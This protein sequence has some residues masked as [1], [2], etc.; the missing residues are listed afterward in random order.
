MEQS[1]PGLAIDTSNRI[2][3][4]TINRPEALNAINAEVMLSLGEI[5][6]EIEDNDRIAGI[7]ITG[8][9]EKAFVAGADI[10]AF[11]FDDESRKIGELGHRVFN[12][13]ESCSKPVV[14][15]VNGFALGG[16]CELAMSCHLRLAGRHA[17]FGQPEINLGIIPGYGG[18]QRLPQLVGKGRAL[19]MLLTGEMIDAAEAYRI[20]LVN[21]VVDSGK[22]LEA[23]ELVLKKI[24]GKAPMAAAKIIELVN[25][26]F[27]DPEVGM[28]QEIE[29]FGACFKTEDAV[30]GV[31]AFIE[32]RRPNFVGK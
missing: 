3:T 28:L 10:K 14:A 20:G 9:G 19:E 31:K 5:F 16:G 1:Y 7:I 30:E 25:L 24:I 32:K 6:S 4:I 18:T 13:I 11:T 21:Q 27:R 29:S 17:K 8:A 26:H 12:A 2:L 22:E 15:A 23:A